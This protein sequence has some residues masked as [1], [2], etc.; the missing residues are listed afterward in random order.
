MALTVK[1]SLSCFLLL[2]PGRSGSWN[3]T[4][5]S[6]AGQESSFSATIFPGRLAEGGAGMKAGATQQLWEERGGGDDLQAPSS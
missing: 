6:L 1:P 2:F 3:W 5:L 4:G